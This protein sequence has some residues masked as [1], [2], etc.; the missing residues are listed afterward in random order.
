MIPL[1]YFIDEVGNLKSGT[2]THLEHKRAYLTA[3]MVLDEVE[4]HHIEVITSYRRQ[5][6]GQQLLN[7][8]I[9]DVRE[10]GAKR[11]F[12]EVSIENSPALKLYEKFGFNRIGTRKGYY[13]LTDGTQ[14]DAYLMEKVL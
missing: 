12:L 14:V 11:I 3:Q 10:K 4:L 1:H 9:E 8:L 13:T 5:G 6:L 7:H 2:H